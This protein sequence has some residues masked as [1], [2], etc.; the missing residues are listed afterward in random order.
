MVVVNDHPKVRQ[1]ILRQDSILHQ[2]LIRRSS[3]S[4]FQVVVLASVQ[5]FNVKIIR[6]LVSNKQSRSLSYTIVVNKLLG[7]SWVKLGFL[8]D[9]VRNEVVIIV[10]VE[11]NVHT[12]LVILVAQ[13]HPSLAG[14]R[15]HLK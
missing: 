8:P 14:H 7:H 12:R 2:Y 13:Y 9:V 1:C 10:H 5:I 4:P 11:Y 3:K 15:L 6:S